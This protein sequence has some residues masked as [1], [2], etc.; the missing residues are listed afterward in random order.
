MVR[1]L[2]S[3][4]F[5][6]VELL[7][8]IA[9]IGILVGLLLPAVQSAREAARRLQ[10]SNHLKQF[11][12]AIHNFHNAKSAIP[13]S[14]VSCHHGTWYSELWP[15]MEEAAIVSAWDPVKSYHFQPQSNI[16]VQVAAYYCPAR[17]GPMLSVSG[18]QRGSVAHRP[19]AVGDYAGV[20]GDGVYWDWPYP[21]ANGPIIHDATP[22]GAANGSCGG[23][24]P[25][26]LYPGSKY[27]LEFRH[28]SD[29]L[30]NTI[31]VGEKHVRLDKKDLG[32]ADAGDNSIYNPDYATTVGRFA[33]KGQSLA[34]GPTQATPSTVFGSVH[35]G[36]CQFL[37]GDSHVKALAV[38]VDTTFLGYLAVRDDGHVLAGEDL[39]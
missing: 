19:G 29:G 7:V 13:P 36:V 10:C 27:F 17:R 18:D 21:D 14:R 32:T 25:N 38:T 2:R 16:E 5:T 1:S 15:Y 34:R 4:G 28:I 12:I 35:P 3:R 8:V 30:S 37:Y 24:D 31:F 11:G 9:I 20:L 26:F 23:V 22:D 6:L 39:R 33:G